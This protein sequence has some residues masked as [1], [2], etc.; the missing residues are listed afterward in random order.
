MK[1][2]ESIHHCDRTDGVIS[3]KGLASRLTYEHKHLYQLFP[4]GHTLD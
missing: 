1:I 4:I 3:C 2:V